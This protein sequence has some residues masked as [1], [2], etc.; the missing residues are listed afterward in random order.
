MHLP[1]L[2]VLP[3]TVHGMI[4]ES[5]SG[6]SLT[7]LAIMGL[8]PENLKAKGKIL[9]KLRDRTFDLMQMATKE[10][11]GLRNKHIG[12]VFQEPMTALNPQM[13][14]GD[15]LM[16]ALLV[17]NRC[18]RNEAE[19]IINN[20]LEEVGL[21]ETQRFKNAY[22][23]QISGGQRQRIMIAMATIHKPELV[24]ADEPTTALDPE[25][26]R[27]VMETLIKRCRNTQSAL[28]LVSHELPLVKKISDHVSVLRY[29]TCLA[30]GTAVEVLGGKTMHP[31]VQ[32]LFDA[33][34]HGTRDVIPPAE[35]LLKVKDISKSY[36]L[37]KRSMPVLDG[38]SFSLQKGETLALVGLS[39]SGK[40]TMARI[41]TGLEKTENGEVVYK[42][43]NLL[44]RKVTGI[45]MVF[46][47]PYASLNQHI[48]NLETVAEVL[49]VRTNGKRLNREE[50]ATTA[51]ELLTMVGLTEKQAA[52]FPHN[53]S[54]GQRQRLCI[55]RAL[56]AE[57]EILVLDEA[58]AALDPL[59]QKQILDLLKKIQLETGIIYIFITHNMDVAKTF[60][61]KMA[62]LQDH[63]LKMV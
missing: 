16:E 2:D 59:V 35:P 34:P 20:C 25:T 40:S 3:S 22:P 47:D 36:K 38:I 46:Q 15:Q 37:G 23:H 19:G 44:K 57:P 5:G 17:H 62:R 28:I 51:I 6:K 53:L 27:V 18:G 52:L 31:Y 29:G 9:F 56:A 26:G 21:T 49:R 48:S 60:A 54:G 4:G 39:G 45:Q 30:Q 24:L 13:R 1:S 41:L 8:V 43:Q 42:D 33:L 55:A 63:K 58:V 7:L 12:M 11:Q 10:M 50:A 61:H 14:C 32:E